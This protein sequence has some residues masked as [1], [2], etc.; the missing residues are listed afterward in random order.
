MTFWSSQMLT[1]KPPE[2]LGL[3]HKL[4][5]DVVSAQPQF[6]GWVL[7]WRKHVDGMESALIDLGENLWLQFQKIR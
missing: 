6:H 1:P 4:T 2:G 7:S 3:N 5:R